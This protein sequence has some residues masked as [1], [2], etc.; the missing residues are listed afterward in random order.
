[1][2]SYLQLRYL[3]DLREKRFLFQVVVGKLLAELYLG[4]Y[5]ILKVAN[6]FTNQMT[7][8]MEIPRENKN[9][10]WKVIH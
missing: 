5:I 4:S 8:K 3:Y 1:M 6:F 9:I 7:Q 10:L 2:H